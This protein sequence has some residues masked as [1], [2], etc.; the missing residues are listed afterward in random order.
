MAP[1]KMIFCTITR[2]ILRAGARSQGLCWQTQSTRTW[3]RFLAAPNTRWIKEVD[4][5]LCSIRLYFSQLHSVRLIFLDQWVLHFNVGTT[6]SKDLPC[7][8]LPPRRRSNRLR[9]LILFLTLCFTKICLS[10]NLLIFH[11]FC[12]QRTKRFWD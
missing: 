10:Q 11:I 7:P 3:V 8:S 4:D 2:M 9:N 1:L 5:D 6:L 12:F